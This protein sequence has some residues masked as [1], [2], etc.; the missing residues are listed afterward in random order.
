MATPDASFHAPDADTS[1]ERALRR[2]AYTTEQ[3]LTDGGIRATVPPLGLVAA[4]AA[5]NCLRELLVTATLQPPPA[6]HAYTVS[7]LER[8][9]L[10]LRTLAERDTVDSQAAQRTR[11]L[12]TSV[13]AQ[14][15]EAGLILDLAHWADAPT[16]PP[17]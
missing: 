15:A 11:A 7:A 14:C 2:A 5:L 10:R 13:L 9:L 1:P 17:L 6:S 3:Y 12:V 4:R 8:A 16:Q